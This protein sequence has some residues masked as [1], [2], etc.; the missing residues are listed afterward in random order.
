MHALLGHQFPMG[1][2]QE[3]TLAGR[4]RRGHEFLVGIAEVDHGYDP[5]AW[6]EHLRVT[7][8]GGYRWSNKHLGFPRRIA[9][10]LANPAWHRAVAFL[11]AGTLDPG[12]RTSD[13]VALARGIAADRAF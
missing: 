3:R 12:W 13:V 4:I 10:A 2:V 11:R 5:A 9:L 1:M 6:H 8:A 7:D